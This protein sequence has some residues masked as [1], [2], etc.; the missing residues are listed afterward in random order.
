MKID[1]WSSRF[2]KKFTRK[3]LGGK[4]KGQYMDKWFVRETTAKELKNFISSELQREREKVLEEIKLW[5]PVFY[6]DK[7]TD[8]DRERVIE[9]FAKIVD[10]YYDKDFETYDY[11]QIAEDVISEINS[12]RKK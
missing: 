11:K 4:E 10:K 1:D 5:R 9:E 7:I 12:L 8:E 3:C 6:R 2:D